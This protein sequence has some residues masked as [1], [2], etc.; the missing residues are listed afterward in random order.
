MNKTEERKGYARKC[1]NC[2][3]IIWMQLCN[4]DN[5]RPFDFPSTRND[6]WDLHNCDG[7]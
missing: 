4:D 1:R 5:W 6:D 7:R 2:T 3:T